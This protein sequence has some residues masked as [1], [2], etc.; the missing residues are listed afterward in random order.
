MIF[1]GKSHTFNFTKKEPYEITLNPGLFQF[2][3]WGAQGNT[4]ASTHVGGPGAYTRGTIK[5]TEPKTFFLYVGEQ[6]QH[7]YQISFNGGGAGQH[8]GG[9]A[10]DIRLLNGSWDDFS[11]LK[12]RI[13]VAA[14]GGGPNTELSGGAGG[15]LI[16]KDSQNGYG[17]GGNQTAGGEGCGNGAFGKGGNSFSEEIYDGNG[18]AGSGYYG[19]GTSIDCTDYGGG[20]GSSFISGHPGCIAIKEESSHF[21][22]IIPADTSIHFSGLYFTRTLMIDGENEMP[23]P[24]GGKEKAGHIG[25][26]AIRIQIVLKNPTCLRKSNIMLI[27][28]LFIYIISS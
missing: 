10:S 18:G 7:R 17:K 12:S 24:Y 22:N 20:G 2:E 19:G 23:S 8:G 16:G 14:G 27:P 9:G 28:F 26:G 21:D 13:M 4:S 3:C 6:N 15:G 1:L 25:H 5:L 11:S